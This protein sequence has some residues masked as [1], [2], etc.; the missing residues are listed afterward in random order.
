MDDRINQIAKHLAEILKQLGLRVEDDPELAHTPEKVAALYLEL[1][2]GSQTEA[3]PEI[4]LLE[5]PAGASEMILVRD[6]PFYSMCVPSKEW[7]STPVGAVRAANIR[8]GQQLWT[9]DDNGALVTTTVVSVAWRRARELVEIKVGARAIRVT[10]EHPILTPGGWRPAS[11]LSV[12]DKVRAINPRM[13]SQIRHPVSEGYNMGYVIGA[14]GSDGNVD[15]GR[16]VRLTVKDI[17]FARRF[18]GAVEAAFGVRRP[19]QQIEVWSGFLARPITMYRVRIVSR[20]IATLLLH[21]FGGS[22]RTKEF[23]FPRVVLRSLPMTQGF[24]D[25]YCD[26]DGCN[27]KRPKGA[28]W[29]ISANLPFLEELGRLLGTE[30]RPA[31]KPGT[32]LLYVS[33][34]WYKRGWHGHPGYRQEKVPLLPP[35]GEWTPVDRVSQIRAGGTKPFRVY[36]FECRPYPTFLVR[37]IQAHNCVHH[38]L[39]FFGYGHIAYVPG[40]RLIGISGIGK[41]L[42]HF[43]RRPQL[44][45]RLAAQVADYLQT[46]LT[47][48]GVIVL[49]QARQLCMEMRAEKNTGLVETTAARGCFQEGPHREEFFHR[50][51]GPDASSLMRDAYENMINGR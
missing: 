51:L 9:F 6:V 48:Q 31:T 16:V 3:E 43:A 17:E 32:W 29:I 44:Q 21:W 12:G 8:P 50:L 46:A 7:I 19:V 47:P 5:H 38:F 20:R 27:L 4:S 36:S 34:Q 41:V 2:Q 49:L 45:E 23:H 1:F 18:A 39:P 26:G 10:P 33:R 14:V 40:D 15:D 42:Q 13:L 11:S 28:R 24:L 37:G 30:P 25:G 35:D 22:K